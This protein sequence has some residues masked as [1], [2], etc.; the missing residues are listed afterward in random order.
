[1]ATL[2]HPTIT[3][4]P[5][6]I[7]RDYTCKHCGEAGLTIVEL[8]THGRYWKR[9]GQCT[10]LPEAEQPAIA[11]QVTCEFTCE[12]GALFKLSTGE[13]VARHGIRHC[14]SC[15]RLLKAPRNATKKRAK[16]GTKQALA[17]ESEAAA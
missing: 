3:T 1:M 7:A 12:C 5:T 13:I 14:F 9:S 2:D 10:P 4:I 11:V 15:L 6:D 8:M 16:K 17:G